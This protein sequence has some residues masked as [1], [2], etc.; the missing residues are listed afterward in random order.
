MNVKQ[1]LKG[2]YFIQTHQIFS[3]AAKILG[4]D[5]MADLWK[6]SHRQIYRWGA[7]DDFCEEVTRNP[8]DLMQIR[9][10]HE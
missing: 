7:D 3:A 5:F 1:K 8:L 6:K 2:Q 9:H 10:Y 4:L